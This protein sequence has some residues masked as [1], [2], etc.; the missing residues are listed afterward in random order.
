MSYAAR[1]DPP[2]PPAREPAAPGRGGGPLG[3]AG[4]LPLLR[5]GD[6]LFA[7]R[8]VRLQPAAADADERPAVRGPALPA[9]ALLPPVPVAAQRQGAGAAVHPVRELAAAGGAGAGAQAAAAAGPA[10][11]VHARARAG[12]AA[13]PAVRAAAPAVA[14]GVRPDSDWVISISRGFEF[15]ATQSVDPDN[16]LTFMKHLVER[17]SQFPRGILSLHLAQKKVRI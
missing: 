9:D 6:L 8:P 4:V 1:P 17:K 5:D 15:S 10:D 12:A 16:Q 13:G 14:A 3:P 2:R 7:A 11:I